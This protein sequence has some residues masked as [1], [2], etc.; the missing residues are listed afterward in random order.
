[1]PHLVW[2]WYFIVIDAIIGGVSICSV[3]QG[4][5]LL[6]PEFMESLMLGLIPALPTRTE[7]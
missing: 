2:I 1:M 7:W 4:R 3:G 6:P 5:G